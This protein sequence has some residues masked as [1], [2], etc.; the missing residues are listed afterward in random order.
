MYEF[1]VD[2]LDE[3]IHVVDA[4]GKTVIYNQKMADIE[5]MSAIDVLNKDVLDV[6]TFPDEGYSTLLH[7]VQTGRSTFNVKQTY[8]NVKGESVTTINNT[9]PIILKGEICG[10]VEIA[11]DI[12]KIERIQENILK[13]GETRYTFDSLV[14]ES[15]NIVE[16]MEHAKR[17]ARTN[18]S[19]LIVGE[20]G[21]GKELFAQSIHHASPRSAGPFISQNCA[22]LP[23]HLIEGI[24]FGTMHGAFPGAIDRP[25]L[26]EQAD[27]GTILLDELNSLSLSLQAKLLRALQEKTIRRLGDTQDRTVD[28]RIIATIHEDPLDDVVKGTLRKDLY[29]RLS[30]VTLFLPPLRERQDDIPSL[31]DFFVR[32]Y[33][34]LFGMQ[35]QGVS[36]EVMKYFLTYL[37]PGNV[38]ELEN[39]IEGA[40]NLVMDN[41]EIDVVHLPMHIRR[42]VNALDDTSHGHNSSQFLDYGPFT[43]ERNLQS[44]LSQYERAY[45]LKVLSQN[46]GNVSATAR[47]LGVS[48]QSLQ[49]RLRK[50]NHTT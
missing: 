32:R 8:Y 38:R 31:T 10:A 2:Q 50:W 4:S 19:I 7:A 30:V 46:E 41:G 35:V 48:R 47:A 15:S 12:T 5:S 45:V 16:V 11:R 49:Y 42:R 24:L 3:G 6:F 1:L 20:T 34:E 37:W 21:T 36:D 17:A 22:A 13:R 43:Q 23:E 14:G 39:T 25:G 29:Y 26:L 33:N 28:V 27:G 9:M 44:Q 40:M 18:S